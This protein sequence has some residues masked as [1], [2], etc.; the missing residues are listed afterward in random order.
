L[1]EG[2]N[3][4]KEKIRMMKPKLKPL[5]KVELEKLNKD[6]IIYPIRHYDWISNPMIVRNKTEEIQKCVYFRDLNKASIKDNYPLSNMDFLLQ[7]VMGST[8]MSMLDGFSG[9]NQVLV[10]EED[11][12]KKTFITPWETYA[13]SMMP[14]GLKNARATFQRARD[15]A[16]KGFIGKFMLDYQ[17]DLIVH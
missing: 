5:V 3:P 9:Y 2:E 12:E 11:R 10:T 14:V 16:F 6:G 13:Y 1:R 7:Q 17:Y 15:H 4:V 8:C